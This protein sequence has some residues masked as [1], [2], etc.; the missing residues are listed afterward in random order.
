M[1]VGKC[2]HGPVDYYKCKNVIPAF[3]SFR[4]KSKGAGFLEKAQEDSDRARVLRINNG[5]IANTVIFRRWPQFCGQL[6]KNVFC[7]QCTKRATK[8]HKS[9]F[10]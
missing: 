6:H 5:N 10:A 2:L 3:I 8:V 4:P 9:V 1:T 7:V